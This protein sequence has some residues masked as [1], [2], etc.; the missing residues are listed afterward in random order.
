MKKAELLA[1]AGNL[2]KLKI[3]LKY[4]ADA[5]YIGGEAFSLRVAAKNFSTDEIPFSEF[6]IC[7]KEG[8]QEYVL[9]KMWKRNIRWT[10]ILSW[11]WSRK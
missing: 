9:H 2:Y 10:E 3:A 7:D 11:M 1:P 5:V 6:L 8:E 4:G